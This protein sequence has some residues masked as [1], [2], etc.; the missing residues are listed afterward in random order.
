MRN[1]ESAMWVC[2]QV[3]M[4]CWGE[5][6]GAVL[7]VWSAL[8][9]RCEGDGKKAG[10]VVGIGGQSERTIQTLEDMLRVY[11]IDFAKGWDR[12]LLLVKFSYNNSYH[13]S[14]ET[15]PFEALYGQKCRSPIC[16][17]EFRD[18]QLTG[19]KIIHETTKKIIQI[20]KHIQAIRDRQKSYADRRRKPLEFEVE[21]KVMLKVSPWKG[22]IH[23]G[24]R[25][26][27]NPHYIGPFRI[28]DKVGMLAY[29]LELPDQL[30]RVHST[31]H[32]SN[33][34]KCFVDEPLAIPLDKI[35]IDDK[36]NFI[37][38]PVKLWIEKKI[39]T[40]HGGT[41]GIKSLFDAVEI[42]AAQVYVNIDLIKLA[43]SSDNAQSVVTYTSIS[44]DSDGPSWGIPLM[45]FDELP[46]M[47]PYEEYTFR[48]QSTRS[49]KR[50]QMMTFRHADDTLLTAESP[51]YIVDSDS[52]GKD[53]DE[54]PEE[55]PSEEHEPEDKEEPSEGSDEC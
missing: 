27:L 32:V 53:D 41:I 52:M 7:M 20:K 35:Q 42:T 29:R 22:M 21:D 12:H 40:S 24:K 37:E 39:V 8:Y 3:H 14:I 25:W 34:K 26:K 55:D 46:E 1:K 13:T 36:L 2:E 19:S 54:D 33:L 31:F 10:K 45:N 44:S 23:F 30:I 17:A 49:T 5:G 11:V 38:E 51:G 28:L 15:V 9:G 18:A 47:D 6:L 4:K 16:W 50:H 43:M 48:S